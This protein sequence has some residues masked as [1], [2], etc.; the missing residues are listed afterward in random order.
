M[1]TRRITVTAAAFLLAFS[2][3]PVWAHAAD[4]GQSDGQTSVCQFSSDPTVGDFLERFEP[5]Y[6]RS[7]GDEEKNEVGSLLVSDMPSSRLDADGISG[8]RLGFSIESGRRSDGAVAMR[9]MSTLGAFLEDGRRSHVRVVVLEE[10][11]GRIVYSEESDCAGY[12][13]K[14]DTDVFWSDSDGFIAI[15]FGYVE[16]LDGKAGFP[17]FRLERFGVNRDLK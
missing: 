5:D 3:F 10:D 17:L 4:Y 11:T 6:Y 8:G 12:L 13:E 16:S 14:T 7:L 9:C 15:C 1:S 2:I